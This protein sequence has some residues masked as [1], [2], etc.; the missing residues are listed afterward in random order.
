MVQRTFLRG[1]TSRF[2]KNS[3]LY[4]EAVDQS[5]CKRDGPE[6]GRASEQLR[7]NATSAEYNKTAVQC[8]AYAKIANDQ[9]IFS[10]YSMM[11]VNA[12]GK[13]ANRCVLMTAC[14]GWVYSRTSEQHA[15]KLGG[16]PL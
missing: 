3:G 9:S 13:Q 5:T 15:A 10:S 11:L 14:A 12:P 7:I 1:R 8:V 16:W 6:R 2:I 4:V